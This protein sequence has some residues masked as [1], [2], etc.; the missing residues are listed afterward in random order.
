M[1]VEGMVSMADSRWPNVDA[2]CTKSTV[3]VLIT[4][5]YVG[6]EVQSTLATVAPAMFWIEST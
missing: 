2:F 5:Q 3:L 6:G 1:S 4:S